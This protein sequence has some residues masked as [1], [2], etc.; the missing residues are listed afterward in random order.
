V[1]PYDE[2]PDLIWTKP[3]RNILAAIT[4][5]ANALLISRLYHSR[6]CLPVIFLLSLHTLM[7]EIEWQRYSA[8]VDTHTTGKFLFKRKKMK[9]R[10]V[11]EVWRNGEL[12][13]TCSLTSN[14][15]LLQ[16]SRKWQPGL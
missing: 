6:Q 12:E 14:S 1:I 8:T 7:F 2:L 9:D 4:V 15:W 11:Y 10:T 5:P 13:K 16:T 3:Q